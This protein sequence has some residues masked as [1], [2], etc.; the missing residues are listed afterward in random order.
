MNTEYA[1]M[2]PAALVGPH[3]VRLG[4]NEASAIHQADPLPTGLDK[5]VGQAGGHVYCFEMTEPTLPNVG[6]GIDSVLERGHRYLALVG[7]MKQGTGLLHDDPEQPLPLAQMIPISTDAHICTWWAMNT[8]SEAM[9]MLF[10]GRCTKKEDGTPA[11]VGF[12]F[13][14][15]HNRDT[16]PDGSQDS[17]GSEDDNDDDDDNMAVGNQPELSTASARR[18]PNRSTAQGTGAVHPSHSADVDE[19][20][21]DSDAVSDAGFSTSPSKQAC[22]HL[23][24]LDTRALK[25]SRIGRETDRKKASVLPSL[26]AVS[27]SSKR[28]LAAMAAL[29]ELNS[30]ADPAEPPSKVARLLLATDSSVEVGPERS[31]GEFNSRQ[32]PTNRLIPPICPPPLASSLSHDLAP[33]AVEQVQA[34]ASAEH[35][36][37]LASGVGQPAEPSV[38]QVGTPGRTRSPSDPRSGD[39]LA[40]MMVPDAGR[41]SGPASPACK[42][43]GGYFTAS[44]LR[45]PVP[46]FSSMLAAGTD[47]WSPPRSVSALA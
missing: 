5:I 20:E 12:D 23:G 2:R 33:T 7:A 30:P 28:N 36:L 22:T 1:N 34:R 8:P 31:H 4:I 6:D 10:Y 29:N 44:N 19:L 18:A 46:S 39:P 13:A 9:D 32:Q 21:S 27:S 16:S 40:N 41:E 14:S 37:M 45:L 47:V 11:P 42:S 15:G 17:D 43:R 38:T 26:T 24:N 3:Y 35:L 25:P